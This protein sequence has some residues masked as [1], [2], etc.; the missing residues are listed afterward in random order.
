M[1]DFTTT[2]LAGIIQAQPS[3]NNEAV[4][5]NVSIDSRT[6]KPGDCF[7]AVKGDNFDGHNFIQQAFDKGALCAVANKN[8]DIA[9]IADKNIL[10]VNDTIKALGDLAAEYRKQANFKVV[11]I[12]GSAGKTT[13]RQIIHH[14]L[15]KKFNTCTAPKNYNNYIGLPLTL[16]AA[17]SKTQIVVA[18]LATNK[19]GEIE[20]LTKIAAPDIALITNIHPVHL[21][22][23]GNLDAITEEKASIAQGLNPGGSLIINGDCEKLLNACRNKNITFTTFGKTEHCDIQAANIKCNGLS[24]QAAIQNTQIDIPLPGMGNIENTIAAFSICRLFGI[25]INDFAQA[26]KTLPPIKKRTEPLQIGN[27]TVLNDCYNANP[28]SMKNALDIL[29]SLDLNKKRRLV[30]IC[31]D[32]A[33]LGRQSENLHNN[34]GRQITDAKVNLLITVGDYAK[35]TAQ[36][37]K[38]T[39]KYKIKIFSFKDVDSACNKLEKFIKDYDIILIKGSRS[40]RLEAAIEKLKQ[41]FGKKISK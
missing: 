9:E 14:V 4:I 38:N 8:A 32:M 19:P 15:S 5:R 40:A 31:G 28:A 41:L 25:T 13:T 6:T 21:A 1:K 20:Y 18:E 35:I 33:E 39:A 3:E 24:S 23:L 22:G 17:E 34:L 36:T 26:I 11:A 37:A 27:L 2:E 12:T 10:R 7:F 29:K 30:F 16:L